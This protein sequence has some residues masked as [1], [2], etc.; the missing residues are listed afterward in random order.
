M[1]TNNMSRL[2]NKIERRLGTRVL[3]LPDHLKKEEWA[4][5]IKEETLP[6]F[7]RYI[8]HVVTVA[9]GDVATKKGEY[10]LIDEEKI[11]NV[12]I[13]GAKDI[14]WQNQRNTSIYGGWGSA[15]GYVE[16]YYNVPMDLEGLTGLQMAADTLSLL[17]NTIYVD[18]QYPNKIKLTSAFNVDITTKVSSGYMVTLFIEHDENLMTISPTT[19]EI[20]ENIAVCDVAGYLYNELKYYQNLETVFANIDIKLDDIQSIHQNRETVIQELK[21]GYVT[22][23]NKQQPMIWTV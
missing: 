5:V 4:T 14:D 9:L 23:G 20:F 7:S 15:Y 8:P 22:F 18:F 19:M 1:I 6:T 12:K 10:Y 2:L 3:N 17:N 13:L 21:D 11:G 16:D